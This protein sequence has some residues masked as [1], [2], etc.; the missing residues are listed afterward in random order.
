MSFLPG[1]RSL[2]LALIL[3]AGSSPVADRLAAQQAPAPPAEQTPGGEEPTSS[4]ID[5]AS[6]R[7]K[8]EE[9]QVA[10]N[11]ISE[12]G[13]A[14]SLV[15]RDATQE[16]RQEQRSLLEQ[17]IRG[18]DELLSDSQRLAEARQRHADTSRTSSEWKGFPESP[19]YSIFVADQL[20]DAAYSLKLAMEGLQSQLDLLTLRYERA[21]QSL[22]AAEE[23]LR[24]ASERLEAAKDSPTAARERWLHELSVLRKQAAA[25]MVQAAEL[26]KRR[27]EEEL[28][29]TRT[30]LAFE[31]R[32]AQAVMPHVE[33]SEADLNKVRARVTEERQRLEEELEHILRERR[34]QALAVQEAERQLDRVRAKRSP[35]KAA[36]ARAEAAVELARARMDTLVMRGD[37]LQQVIDVAEGERQLWESR[38]AIVRTAEPGKAREA[39]EKST[40]LFHDF[41]ASRNYLRQQAGII[42]GQISELQNRLRHPSKSQRRDTVE[43]LVQTFQDREN[44][45]SRTLHRV[46]EAA[47]FMERWQSE[48]KEQ[49]KELPLSAHLEDWLDHAVDIAKRTWNYELF[50]AEDTIEVDGKKI[51]GHRSVTVGKVISALGILVIGYVGC[52]YLAKLIGRMAATRLGMA[53]DV[54]NLVRQWSQAVLITLLII[55]SFMSVKIPLTIFAFLGGAF[56]IGVGFGA[57]NLLKNIISGILVLIER[58]LRV[59]DLIEVDNIRGRVTSIGLRSSTVRDAKGMDTLIPNSSFLERHLTNWTYSSRISRFSLRVGAPYGASSQQVVQLLSQLAAEHSRVL[60]RPEPQVLLEDFGSQARIFTLNYWLEI[61]PDIDPSAVA[62]ELRFAIE[63]SFFEAGHKVLP[64]A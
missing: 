4:D 41:L 10:L 19:P 9:A 57:Q 42:S 62:S 18:Y 13:S 27:V 32:R 43:G 20:W 61:R 49:Q 26:S 21:R 5:S 30:R 58:P 28:A 47:R 56:A 8:R 31:Q 46:D 40:P 36:L 37:L 38:Y 29:E 59:G 1:S 48:F 16:E 23:G 55:I 44:A 12:R 11:A 17:I 25:V 15:P 3:A 54:A 50:S 2:C 52:L 24:Q 60:K 22:T 51:T 39:Y 6:F 34:R 35:S 7:E 33:F 63:R 53:P 14:T 64:A 45:Y